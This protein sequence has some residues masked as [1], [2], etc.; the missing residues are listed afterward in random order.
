MLTFEGSYFT[1]APHRGSASC[2]G[3]ASVFADGTEDEVV[4]DAEVAGVED[5]EATPV[6]DVAADS[7]GAPDDAPVGPGGTLA[8]AQPTT[9]RLNDRS[10]RVP[11]RRGYVSGAHVVARASVV[12][13]ATL[14]WMR[15][16]RL[17]PAVVFVASAASCAAPLPPRRGAPSALLAVETDDIKRPL[18]V[19]VQ[20]VGE[21]RVVAKCR[22]A[23]CELRLPEGGYNLHVEGVDDAPASTRLVVLR[24]PGARVYVSPG[25]WAMRGSGLAMGI[26]GPPI[27]AL[28]GV[29]TI[30]NTCE[31]VEAPNTPCSKLPAVMIVS[32]LVMTI[33]GWV[34]FSEG[35]T[36]IDEPQPMAQPGYARS[37]ALFTF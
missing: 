31:S 27:L 28:G 2:A 24:G 3:S 25:S 29:L 8:P 7:V 33:V 6:G 35:K 10:A 14:P 11:I 23:P 5:V 32:G 15:A 13:G 20:P 18:R 26:L 16:T 34:L 30:G 1:P 37:A 21:E 22:A 36:R 4:G 12:R 9:T 19:E 17:L